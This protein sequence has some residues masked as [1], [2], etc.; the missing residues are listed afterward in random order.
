[1][2]HDIRV[3]PNLFIMFGI[4]F[5]LITIIRLI[6]YICLDF[7]VCKQQRHIPAC[8]SA[9]SDQ[10]IFYL[11]ICKYNIVCFLANFIILTSH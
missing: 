9:Q 8:I 3:I 1:M 6:E 7:G 10:Q 5:E 2:L 11:R 4:F